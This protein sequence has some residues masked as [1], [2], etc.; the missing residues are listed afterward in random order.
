[1]GQGIGRLPE[2]SGVGGDAD[3]GREPIGRYIAQ[4]RR[5]R[6]IELE[7]LAARTRIP[8]RSLERL[9]A[10]AFDHSPDGFSRGFVRTVAEAIGLD[11]DD[12][13][14]RMLP[15]PD[16]ARRGSPRGSRMLGAIAAAVALVGLA[17][18]ARQLFA[19][20][21]ARLQATTASERPV[22][23]DYV[24]AL[25]EA[26]GIA[27][28]KL[29]ARDAVL[30]PLPPPPAS[31]AGETSELAAGGEEAGPAPLA[32]VPPPAAARPTTAPPSPAREPSGRPTTELGVAVS[33]PASAPGAAAAERPPAPPASEVESLATSPAAPGS[34][35]G[36][37]G[38]EAGPAAN[39][40]PEREAPSAPAATEAP[41]A[42][43]IDAEAHD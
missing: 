42:A 41:P 35:E 43:T 6:G 31:T 9:E 34:G 23:R 24:R 32:T 7:D 33:P 28:A 19:S 40:R 14:A 30:A 2:A 39:D 12:A 25:A 29:T 22:R 26:Q 16:A 17:L 5:L 1:M 37:A 4:Q 11:P 13:V 38:A 8:R 3:L 18:A 36:E 20:L 27:T 21:P 10:G 15:E